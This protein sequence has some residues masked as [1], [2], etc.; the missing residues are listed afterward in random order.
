M[1]NAY[2]SNLTKCKIKTSYILNFFFFLKSNFT[3]RVEFS[4]QTICNFGICT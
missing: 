1:A 3:E 2:K 4:A